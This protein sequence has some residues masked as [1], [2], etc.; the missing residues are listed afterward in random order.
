MADIAA[1]AA[2]AADRGCVAQQVVARRLAEDRP[3]PGSEVVSVPDREPA[4][5]RG[6]GL[7][8]LGSHPERTEGLIVYGSVVASF[9]VEDFGVKRLTNVTNQDIEERYKSFTQLTDFHT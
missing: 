7:G 6:Q 4:G 9:T 8:T 3:R 5:L 1:E 2:V